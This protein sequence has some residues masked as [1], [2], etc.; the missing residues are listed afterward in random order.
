MYIGEIV[1]DAI[2]DLIEKDKVTAL[3]NLHVIGHS[4][5]AHV[6]G[7]AGQ[8][9]KNKLGT[10]LPWI[11][12][13]DPAGPLYEIP[14]KVPKNERLSNDDGK[15]VE[16]VHTDGGLLGFHSAIGTIDFYPN[17][18]QFIQPNCSS[19]VTK[20]FEKLENYGEWDFLV[21]VVY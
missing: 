3:K 20:N 7:F 1:G 18:G 13:L 10:P 5:G 9:V 6:A 21:Y 4:L 15:V 17:G 2:V 19:T 11:T 14:V 16:V 8:Q 12:G